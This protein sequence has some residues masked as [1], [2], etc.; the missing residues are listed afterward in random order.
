MRNILG[1][2]VLVAM[3]V[4]GAGVAGNAEHHYNLEGCR[5]VE[6]HGTTVVAED[7]GGNLW[8][9]DGEGYT[10]GA[11]ITLKMHTNYTHETIYDDVVVEVK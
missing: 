1:C 4:V 5:V 7:K 10:L 2:I 6:V 11:R 3:F 8:E 9:F